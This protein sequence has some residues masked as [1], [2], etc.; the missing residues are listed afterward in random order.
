[1]TE[2]K[3]KMVKKVFLIISTVVVAITC[4]VYIFASY[5]AFKHRQD[6]ALLNIGEEI[7]DVHKGVPRGW[8]S[9]VVTDPQQVGALKPLG[10]AKA[11]ANFTL[12]DL[13]KELKG[14]V[15]QRVIYFYPRS[16]EKSIETILQNPSGDCS[17][18]LYSQTAEYI[19]LSSACDAFQGEEFAEIER[20]LKMELEQ[21]W[22]K[23]Q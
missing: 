8:S 11:Q 5:G 16:M 13:N 1:M 10:K 21:F 19:I 7:I 23:Y 22:F 20:K 15:Q 9:S 17:P 12:P 4:I 18:E 3:K 14:V 2:Q 6:M